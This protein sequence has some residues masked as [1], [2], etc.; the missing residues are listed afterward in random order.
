MIISNTFSRGDEI[1][2]NI[3]LREIIL[4]RKRNFMLNNVTCF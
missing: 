3:N 2:G 1:R 4:R